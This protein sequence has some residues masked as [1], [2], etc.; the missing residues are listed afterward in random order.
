MS[1]K[2]GTEAPLSDAI[3]EDCWTGVKGV[4]KV[5]RSDAETLPFVVTLAVC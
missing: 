5:C 2:E 4:G 3:L 1:C